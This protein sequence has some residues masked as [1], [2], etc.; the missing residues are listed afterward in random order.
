MATMASPVGE[1]L[2]LDARDAPWPLRPWI[3]ATIC[4]VAGLLFQWLAA[5]DNSANYTAGRAALATGILIGTGAFVVTVEQRLWWWALLFAVGW[6]AVIG[7][8]GLST[9]RYGA[10]PTLFEWPFFSG[11]VAVLVAAPL[12]QTARD[13]GGWRFPHVV[14]HGHAWGDAV[15]GAAGFAFVGITFL[16][17]ALIAGLFNI[18]GITLLQELLHKAWFGWMLAGFA[19]GAAIGLMRERDAL[20]A[21]LQRLVMIVLGVLAPVLAVAL[22]AFLASLP[23]AGLAGLW[24]GWISATALTLAAAAGAQL[25][26]NSA[27]GQGDAAHTVHPVLRW[28]ALALTLAV[29][30]LAALALTAL[31]LRIA[32]YGWTPERIWGVIAGCVA[33][34]YGLIGLWSVLRGRLRFDALLRPLQV[35]AALGVCALALVLALPIVDFGA[36]AARD[37]LARLQAGTTS[38][39]DFDWSAM[40]FDF[41]PEGRRLLHGVARSGDPGRSLPARAA[42]SAGSRYNVVAQRDTLTSDRD[43]AANVRV[44]P[45]GAP[46]SPGL[47]TAIVGANM[48]AVGVCRAQRL[49]HDRWL[50]VGRRVAGGEADGLV[51]QRD[52]LDGWDEVSLRWAA[53]REVQAPTDLRAARI[54]LRPVQRQQLVVDGVNLGELPD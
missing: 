25:L 22:V 17:A 6:G 2:R 32:Q 8:V 26:L 23:V 14:A 21:T 27:I 3:M 43:F 48:C 39:A 50:L 4:A 54:E 38:A 52:A 33:A 45:A 20:V 46:I 40:A 30:P 53:A 18:I 28:S 31:G 44:S 13:E 36:F 42:L 10:N 12:F 15:I 7:I 41:G 29:L 49:R 19:F 35:Q 47:R 51:L 9:G 1:S 11:I 37:Q 5:F 16:L 24:D 34:T